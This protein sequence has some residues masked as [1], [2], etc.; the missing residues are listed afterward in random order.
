[1]TIKP[2]FG[3]SGWSVGFVIAATVIATVLFVGTEFYW[4][5]HPDPDD[6]I[7]YNIT[8]LDK[9]WSVY[10]HQGFIETE[11][12]TMYPYDITVYSQMILGESY[13]VFTEKR[14]SNQIP[15]IRKFMRIEGV[16]DVLD[17]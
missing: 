2:N 4:D 16:R 1:M 17:E 5:E 12:G 13:V 8:V 7:T 9:S 15:T 3:V 11:Y 6:Y 10:C 14:T